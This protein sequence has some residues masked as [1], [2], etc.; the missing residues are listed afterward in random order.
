MEGSFKLGE[1]GCGSGLGFPVCGDQ[2]AAVAG[3]KE[4]RGVW[5]AGTAALNPDPTICHAQT[6]R[7]QDEYSDGRSQAGWRRLR[8]AG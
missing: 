4:E 2:G 6:E 3:L 7:S 8:A 5:P 1:K